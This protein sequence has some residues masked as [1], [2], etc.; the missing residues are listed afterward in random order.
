MICFISIPK[1]INIMNQLLLAERNLLGEEE[2]KLF[3]LYL[4][5]AMYI[6]G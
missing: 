2:Q 4:C 3:I 6:G 5:E 1:L